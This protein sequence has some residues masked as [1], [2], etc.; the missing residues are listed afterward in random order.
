[1][2]RMAARSL[3]VTSRCLH[4]H[5]QTLNTFAAFANLSIH[6]LPRQRSYKNREA[7]SGTFR[8]YSVI[9][10]QEDGGTVHAKNAE[11][12]SLEQSPP[13]DDLIENTTPKAQPAA[14]ESPLPWYLQL[15]SSD[16]TKSPFPERQKLPDLPADSPPDLLPIL[17]HLSVDIGLEELTLL[18]LRKLDPPPALGANLIMIFGTTRSE[19]H[20][21]VSAD[22][23][24]RWLRSNYKLTP[25]ADGLLGRNELKLKLRRK[26]KRA[27]LLGS[28]RT[29][30]ATEEDDG[31][32][33]GWVCVNVG[34]IDK[35]EG[36]EKS[37][38]GQGIVGF[39]GRE[40]GTKLVVQMMT[41][42]KREEVGL[43][44]LWGGFLR[45]QNKKE[46][47]SI[48]SDKKELQTDF[49]SS[50]EVG[51]ST[52]APTHAIADTPSLATSSLNLVAN[53][54]IRKKCLYS[55]RS[56]ISTIR[57]NLHTNI[58]RPSSSSV[59][60]PSIWSTPIRSIAMSTPPRANPAKLNSH[61]EHLSQMSQIDAVKA[62]GAGPQDRNSTPFLR[63]FYDSMLLFP[64]LQDWE[65][66]FDFLLLATK[67]GH[68][69]YTTSCLIELLYGMQESLIV[70]PP[71]L[72]EKFIEALLVR[73][74]NINKDKYHLDAIKEL[75]EDMS[76]R[77]TFFLSVHTIEKLLLR[78]I[79]AQRPSGALRR[80]ETAFRHVLN[81]IQA[82]KL[83]L[84]DTSQHARIMQALALA[85]DW[86][87]YWYYWRGFPR[88]MQRRSQSLYAEMFRHAAA[89][90]HQTLCVQALSTSI[91]EMSVEVP[92]VLISGDLAMSIMQCLLVADPYVEE[93]VSSGSNEQSQWVRLWKRCQIGLSEPPKVTR[94]ESDHEIEGTSAERPDDRLMKI[95]KNREN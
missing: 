43:E 1:M 64:D 38:D 15:Q 63:S 46:A 95:R 25:Y 26:A 24:C 45:R 2:Y 80:N 48:G 11:Q 60:I 77:G 18:D 68:S 89:S 51:S 49:L 83:S 35:G 36:I 81:L 40:D 92:P 19:R 17:E 23:F 3:Q 52:E 66:R 37:L 28:A 82:R 53:P 70:V 59:C 20:L 33:T 54:L 41:E 93:E 32:R 55:P 71:A 67:V 84:T 13:S 14:K 27:K 12:P 86:D 22:R 75:L 79:R 62:L 69:K 39:G 76:L 74:D 8:H 16:Q 78:F 4:C 94:A 73:E 57:V 56:M 31:I 29:S 58:T 87:D 30:K 88:C 65:T 7:V 47:K 6:P 90:C 9:P 50:N 72:L 44:N 61:L 10:A 34:S 5:Y 21:H 91:P 85:G 42:E